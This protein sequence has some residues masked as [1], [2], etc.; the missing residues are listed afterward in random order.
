[1]SKSSCSVQQLPFPLPG[2]LRE[3]IHSQMAGTEPDVALAD[4]NRASAG[5]LIITRHNDRRLRTSAFDYV[6]T[7]TAGPSSLLIETAGCWCRVA[8]PA[9]PSNSRPATYGIGSNSAT[10]PRFIPPKGSPPTPCTA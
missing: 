10:P 1:V 4:G 2:P 7:A 5:E 6:K 8:V 3:V 9:A